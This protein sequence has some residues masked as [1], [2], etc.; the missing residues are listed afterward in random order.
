MFIEGLIDIEWLKSAGIV[1]FEDEPEPVL[2]IRSLIY[3]ADQLRWID[4]DNA[5]DVQEARN[6][7][8][9]SGV[10]YRSRG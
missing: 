5:R 2:K 3:K 1:R 7:M 4:W 10:A 8:E 6:I 9:S